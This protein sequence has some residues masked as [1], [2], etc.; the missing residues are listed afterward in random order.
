VN[1]YLICWDDC[2]KKK[3][4]KIAQSSHMLVGCT[5]THCL[6]IARF[7]ELGGKAYYIRLHF[8]FVNLFF[9]VILTFRSYL[10]NHPI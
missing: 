9:S 10:S 3:S 4:T 2:D 8:V 6:K 5:F 1:I 7:K